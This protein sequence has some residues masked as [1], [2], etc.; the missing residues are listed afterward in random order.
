METIIDY[1]MRLEKSKHPTPKMNALDVY[2]KRNIY[3][4]LAKPEE[5][6]DKDYSKER[7]KIR[8]YIRKDDLATKAQGGVIDW[9]YLLQAAD[10]F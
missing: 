8:K 10:S 6:Y 2:T 9:Q 7:Q 3:D 4:Y 5:K 1:V